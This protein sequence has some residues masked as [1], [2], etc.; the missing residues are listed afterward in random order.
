MAT[1]APS[2]LSGSLFGAALTA[3]SVYLPSV[4]LSQLSLTSTHMLKA[5][6]TAS[7]C[8]AIIIYLTNHFTKVRLLPRTNTNYGWFNAYDAN[9]VGGLLQGVGMALTGA[10]PGTVLVQ[11]ALGMKTAQSVLVGGILGGLA[12]VL[13]GNKIRRSEDVIKGGTVTEHTVQQRLKVKD[14]TAVL[15]YE[16][17]LIGMIAT[18]DHIGLSQDQRDFWV[19]PIV[20][21]LMI[22]VAQASSVLL[23]KKT[24]GISSAYAEVATL[25][26]RLFTGAG[27]QVQYSN[28]VFAAGVMAGAKLASQRVPLA[29]ESGIDMSMPVALLGGFCSI[30]GGRLAGGCT[31]GHGISGM[32]TLSVSSFVTVAAMFGGGIVFKHVWDAI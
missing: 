9:I 20:G 24:L 14:E 25:F 26:H 32:S 17:M 16:L 29:A 18:I 1:I 12:F 7:A 21:G 5:F 30:F 4:I 28:I 13:L 2:F 15:G 10:C 27:M 3:S 19:S 23:S 22:G 31:S 11:V 8:S 6:L